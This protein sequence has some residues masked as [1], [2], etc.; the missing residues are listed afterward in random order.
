MSNKSQEFKLAPLPDVNSKA[1]QKSVA[2]F[3]FN[4]LT[5]QIKF[6][7]PDN[8]S[9]P[10]TPSDVYLEISGAK[11][12]W[13][14]EVINHC[15]PKELIDACHQEAGVVILKGLDNIKALARVPGVELKGKEI[16]FPEAFQSIVR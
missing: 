16:L 4:G 13:I 8:P 14:A 2:V 9:T 12:E 5:K 11:S 1:F 10:I 15:L 6:E 7:E 3:N